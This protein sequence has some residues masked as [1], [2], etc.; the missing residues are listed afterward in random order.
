MLTIW[1]VQ[2]AGRVGR[3]SAIGAIEGGNRE[4]VLGAGSSYEH[5][6]RGRSCE[7]RCISEGMN[8]RSGGRINTLYQVAG[9]DFSW[10]AADFAAESCLGWEICTGA[11]STTGARLGTCR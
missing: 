11:K 7:L 4:P 6:T 8:G 1:Q 3:K 2:F 9:G 10:I 5:W